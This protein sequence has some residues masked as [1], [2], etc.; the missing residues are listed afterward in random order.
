VASG[1]YGAAA[2]LAENLVCSRFQRRVAVAGYRCDRWYVDVKGASMTKAGATIVQTV[3]LVGWTFA[4]VP[5]A[6]A[7]V[8]AIA[9]TQQGAVA[10]LLSDNERSALTQTAAA[11]PTAAAAE[12][13]GHALLMRRHLAPAAWMYAA[14]VERDPARGSAITALGVTLAEGATTGGKSSASEADLAAAVELQ[15]EA[16]RLM[17]KEGV[18]HHNLGTAL[19]RLAQARGNDRGLLEEAAKSLREAVALGGR[20]APHFNVRLAEAL[21]ALG[22]R[23]GAEAALREAFAVNPTDPVLMMARRASLADVPAQGGACKVDFNCKKGCPP[24]ITGRIMMV[25]CEIANSSAVSA[26]RDGK[27][28]PK[29][30]NC[31]RKMP[32]FGI[33]IPGLDPGFSIATPW[34]SIDVAM[35]GDGR[36]DWRVRFVTPPVGGFQAF[37]GAEGG[38]NPSSGAANWSFSDGGVQYNLFNSSFVAEKANTF[39]LGASGVWRYDGSTQQTKVSL[40]AGRGV[41]LSN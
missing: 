23:K 33:F 6:L 7:D 40:D 27:P 37:T 4:G 36:I 39:D 19:L 29:G 31:E 18:A 20:R 32:R 10:A 5:N 28:Y 12:G 13:Y 26:C 15:R 14:A 8:A 21:L 38:Y 2:T 30:F 9:R 35:Q 41:L 17:P 11:S 24:G 1:R 25:E 16:V 22:D 3:L 34:G